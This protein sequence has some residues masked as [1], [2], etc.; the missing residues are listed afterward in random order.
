MLILFSITSLLFA[1]DICEVQTDCPA[2]NIC[3]QLKNSKTKESTTMCKETKKCSKDTDCGK[4]QTCTAAKICLEKSIKVIDSNH[5]LEVSNS[6]VWE[7]TSGCKS[8]AD[9]PKNPKN[10]EKTSCNTKYGNCYNPNGTSFLDPVLL[11]KQ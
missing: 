10:A 2:N 9:C 5:L 4:K 7:R 3:F 1:K 6:F 11:E 8:D